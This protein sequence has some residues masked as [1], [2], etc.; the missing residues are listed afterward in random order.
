MTN[1]ILPDIAATAAGT[2]QEAVSDALTA[3][4]TELQNQD[5]T[6]AVLELAR[7]LENALARTNKVSPDKA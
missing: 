1:K 7:N 6:P 2:E 3:L 4:L 5:V